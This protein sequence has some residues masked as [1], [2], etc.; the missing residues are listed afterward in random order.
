MGGKFDPTHACFSKSDWVVLF[1]NLEGNQELK[2]T[3][4]LGGV[5]AQDYTKHG[6]QSERI[7]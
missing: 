1:F 4:F 3:T 2:T 6:F 7:T 5:W